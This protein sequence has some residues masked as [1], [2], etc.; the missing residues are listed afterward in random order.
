MKKEDNS[1]KRNRIAHLINMGSGT[2]SERERPLHDF[3]TSDPITID[4][5][6]KYEDLDINLWECACGTGNLSKRLEEKGYNVLSTDLVDRGFGI[7][8]VDFLK[9][10]K[11]FK[12]DIITNPPFNISAEF[13]LKG[14]E[15]SNRKVCMFLKLQFLESQKRYDSI[16]KNHPPSRVYVFTKR[17]SCYPNDIKYDYHSGITF[18][19]YVWDKQ[20]VGY[21]QIR[22]ID[23]AREEI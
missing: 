22:W 6:L 14:L 9:Q 2:I 13:V 11:K 8:G 15:L 18:C 1:Y 17:I 7:S 3:I 12:G 21:P 23:M 20:Y 19:W 4:Y 5:L 10:T 16:F